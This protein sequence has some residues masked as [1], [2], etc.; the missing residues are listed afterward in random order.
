MFPKFIDLLTVLISK[1]IFWRIALT[2]LAS[3]AAAT[4]Q[5]KR[6]RQAS[7]FERTAGG[8]EPTPKGSKLTTL[9]LHHRCKSSLFVRLDHWP[10]NWSRGELTQVM[11]CVYDHGHEICVWSQPDTKCVYDRTE[12]TWEALL[13][14][15]G[16][17]PSQHPGTPVKHVWSQGMDSGPNSFNKWVGKLQPAYTY[18]PA[19]FHIR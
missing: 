12:P 3:N 9:P 10:A 5:R 14:Q 18:T 16:S 1:S 17:I 4:I 19:N 7:R 15:S 8:F 2:V 6:S 11:K 13:R